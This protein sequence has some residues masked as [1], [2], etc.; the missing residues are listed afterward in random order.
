MKPILDNPY[1]YKICYTK[2]HFKKQY[3]D[4]FHVHTYR[5]AMKIKKEYVT[6]R[7]HKRKRCKLNYQ[8]LPITKIEVRKGIWKNPF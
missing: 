1:G 2:Q 4:V 3:I 7:R 5:N 8:V 6:H